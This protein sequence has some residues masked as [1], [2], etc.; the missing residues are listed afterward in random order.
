VQSLDRIAGQKDSSIFG[1]YRARSYGANQ[2]GGA[3]SKRPI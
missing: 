3:A 1:A 2:V